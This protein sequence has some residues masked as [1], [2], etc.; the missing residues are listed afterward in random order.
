MPSQC[1]GHRKSRGRFPIWACPSCFVLFALYGIFPICPGMVQGLSRLVLFLFLSLLPAPTRN[2]LE[3]VRDTIRTFPE[4]SGKPPS[5]EA[6]PVKIL[7]RKALVLKN[8]RTYL[9]QHD[10]TTFLPDNGN[11]WGKFCAVPRSHPLRP[12]LFCTLFNKGGNRRALR[13]PGEG[14][15][16]FHC[17]V[18]PSPGHMRCWELILASFWP[19]MF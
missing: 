3:R 4:K 5:L 10:W 13:L 12:L 9:P 2:S 7:S 8:V 19:N 17:T 6:P 15:D 18:E 11:D 1:R 14:G 16:H